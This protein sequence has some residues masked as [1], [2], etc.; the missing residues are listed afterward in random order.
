[1]LDRLVVYIVVSGL[2]LSNAHLIMDSPRMELT[3]P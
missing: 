3:S 1:M 2:E